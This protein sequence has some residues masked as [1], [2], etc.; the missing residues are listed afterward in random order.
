VQAEIERCL[1]PFEEA[2]DLLQNHFLVSVPSQPVRSLPRSA[3]T[4]EPF[5]DRGPFGF[6]GWVVPEQQG[7]CRRA[8]D[9]TN[10]PWQRVATVLHWRGCLGEHQD[11]AKYFHALFNRL[12]RRRGRHRAA[13]AVAHSLLIVVYHVLRTRQPYT[14]L[15]V[16][17]LDR[18]DAARI[19][20]HHVR[21]LEQ[22]GNTITLMPIAG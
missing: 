21:R 13:M 15:G 10:E 14:E 3:R 6:L 12:A 9:R 17:Y 20:R 1:L 19:E 22:L 8:N 18:L 4:H 2:L 7:E 5:S 16:V 11:G